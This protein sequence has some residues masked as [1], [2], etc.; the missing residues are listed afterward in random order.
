[1]PKITLD[2]LAEMIGNGFLEVSEKLAKLD[3]GQKDLKLGQDEI[4]TKISMLELGQED[5]VLK[6][7]NFAYKFE[8]TDL[9]KRVTKLERKV[10]NPEL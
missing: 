8:V 9:K 7:D 4:K 10:N 2:N 6:L 3:S 5:I 1:M